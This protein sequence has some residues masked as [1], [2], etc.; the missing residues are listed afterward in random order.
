MVQYKHLQI[1]KQA[2]GSLLRGPSD[3]G[4]LLGLVSALVDLGQRT[5]EARPLVGLRDAD[6]L[7][8]DNVGQR[9]GTEPSGR[10]GGDGSSHLADVVN[11]HM[12]LRVPSGDLLP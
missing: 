10:T 4:E 5:D 8:E 3:V 12:T 2:Q 11:P 9:D 7:G 1:K 6:L